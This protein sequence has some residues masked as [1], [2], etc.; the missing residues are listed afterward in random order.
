MSKFRTYFPDGLLPDLTKP[1]AHK[2]NWA[3]HEILPFLFSQIGPFHLSLATFNISE[4]ALRPLFLMGE[5][6]YFLSTRFLFDYNVRRHKIDMM[7]FA[8]NTA[9]EV[10]TSYS[11]MK[12]LLAHNDNHS[13]AMA[14][15]A[16][17]NRNPR[18]EAGIFSTD[19]AIFNY[20]MDY[21]N[22]VF[23]NDS[24]PFTWE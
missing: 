1:Y 24:I 15:S 3:V 13:F 23:T 16:N 10:R 11:H 2:G 20:Y 7:F 19:P 22:N 21:Y 6:K 5:K 8:S 14:G 9:Q 18:H 4:D 17:M 12:L